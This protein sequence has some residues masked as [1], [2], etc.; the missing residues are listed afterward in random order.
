MSKSNKTA[1]AEAPIGLRLLRMMYKTTGQLF[2][3]Y[4]GK[5][6][7]EQWFTAARF[8]TPAYEL[9]ALNSASRETIEVNGLNIAVYI[10]QDKTIEPRS[11]LLFIHGWMGRGTQIAKYI[12]PLNAIGY[13]VI[14]FDGP[15]HGNTPG[16][17]TSV[18]EFT[19]VVLAL[20]K[21]YGPFD[22]AITHS[23]GGMVLAYAMSLGLKLN[24]AA[25][26]CPPKDFQVLIENFQRILTLPDSVMRVMLRK[27][28][29]SHGQIIRDAVDTLNNVKNLTCKGLIIHDEDDIEISWRSSEEIAEAWPASRF[30]K[31]TGLGHRRIIHDK[32]VIKHI[33][34]FL[35]ERH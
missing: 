29:A 11:S 20:D 15:A 18:L 22:A 2:P 19:D 30:I 31:T 28:Y 16:K 17:Q 3:Q 14:S 35:K 13:R 10:W 25:C 9:P 4:F 1:T 8:K 23:F 12:N 26:I 5:L 34:D 6:A 7:Y 32:E 24:L 21:H 33:V 27:L